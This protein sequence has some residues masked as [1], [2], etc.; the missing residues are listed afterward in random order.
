[1]TA[2]DG[3]GFPKTA[4]EGSRSKR[5]QELSIPAPPLDE[6]EDQNNLKSHRK[7]KRKETGDMVRGLEAAA[8]AS[9]GASAADTAGVGA[10]SDGWVT[11]QLDS[12]EGDCLAG[13]EEE[14][15]ED[16]DEE[17]DDDMEARLR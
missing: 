16:Y 17:G 13:L 6:L 12:D 14:E 3:D 9:G 4:K 11:I 10:K 15:E 7:A 5:G 2:G 1:M 8:A